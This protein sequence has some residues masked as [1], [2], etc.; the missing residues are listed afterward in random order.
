MPVAPITY[1]S[2]LRR[3]SSSKT[4]AQD[5]C[6]KSANKPRAPRRKK[7][8]L[9]VRFLGALGLPGTLGSNP[10]M[11][12][13][14]CLPF[15][16]KLLT[17]VIPLSRKAL[18]P[19]ASSRQR[20][21][22]FSELIRGRIMPTKGIMPFIM[23][24]TCRVANTDE[25]AL[26]HCCG[27]KLPGAGKASLSGGH[28]HPIEEGYRRIEQGR[29]ASTASRCLLGAD[30]VL[31]IRGTAYPLLLRQIPYEMQL[32]LDPHVLRMLSYSAAA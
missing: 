25:Q 32:G 26:C 12:R 16:L 13:V 3:S 20:F 15:L 1:V 27:A 30:I 14:F 6:A 5:I 19:F 29:E 22:N 28:T 11:I 21:V 8:E 4:F 10:I 7:N 2:W 9:G 31:L 23:C 24:R 18:R 17:R